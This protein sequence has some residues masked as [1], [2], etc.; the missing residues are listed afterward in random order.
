I[1]HSSRRGVVSVLS[2]MFLVL[3][4][5]LAA[6]MAIASRGNLQTAASHLHVMRALGAAETG[7]DIAEHRLAEAVSRFVVERGKVDSGLGK[8]LWEGGSISGDLNVL[9]LRDGTVPGS[10]ADA[11]L[12]MH[13]WDG[14]IIP[15]D[16]ISTPQLG[17]RPTSV[18]STTYASSH[19]VMTPPIG[20][21]TQVPG[22]PPYG[23]A[24][25][26]TYA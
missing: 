2:M 25:Q 8:A 24:F 19:W 22:N 13:D 21:E 26:I 7:M 17:M 20:L 16:G 18:S 9:P 15:F 12:I 3:F 23:P 6:A 11:L 10:I 4:G 14:N 5:S 1:H